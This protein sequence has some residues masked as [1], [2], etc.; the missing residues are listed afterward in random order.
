MLTG[1]TNHIQPVTSKMKGYIYRLKPKPPLQPSRCCTRPLPKPG[2]VCYSTY[3]L[4]LLP[5][6]QWD[7][8]PPQGLCTY[9]SPSCAFLL[10]ALD[11]SHPLR[12][13][14]FVLPTQESSAPHLHPQVRRV[15]SAAPFTRRLLR[16]LS[17]CDG[18]QGTRDLCHFDSQFEIMDKLFLEK[19]TCLFV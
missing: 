9:C 3:L 18:K 11:D 17:S 8:L 16:S 4:R 5:L 6:C 15:G 10:L 7:P 14:F 1:H 12:K 2:T 19:L 13:P